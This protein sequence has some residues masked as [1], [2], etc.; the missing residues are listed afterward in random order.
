MKNQS[1]RNAMK[2]V[3][4][5]GTGCAMTGVTRSESAVGAGPVV[6]S[7]TDET[8]VLTGVRKHFVNAAERRHNLFDRLDD[9]SFYVFRVRV[10]V[11]H[12]DADE[13]QL[14]PG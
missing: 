8:I 2:S 11:G 3:L 4:L 12:V 7:G 9:V 10:A 1:R 14:D 5:M 6:G 13:R